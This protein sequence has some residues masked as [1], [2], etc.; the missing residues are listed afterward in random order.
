[1]RKRKQFGG[2]IIMPRKNLSL[3]NSRNAKRGLQK[4]CDFAKGILGSDITVVEVGAFSG[5]SGRIF[6]SNFAKV[7]S[8]DPWKSGYDSTGVDY[9]SDPAYYDMREV[10]ACFDRMTK[11]MGNVVKMKMSSKE[12]SQ[13]VNEPIR[14]VYIDA[15]HTYDGVTS[16]IGLWIDKI[17]RPGIICGHDYISKHHKGV[18]KAVD[19][20]FMNHPIDRMFP[21][22]S[23]L[24]ILN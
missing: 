21:D 15:W 1:M 9:A 13:K 10:E 12:A 23:W 2:G 3:R 6:A 24:K 14:L 5:D 22:S 7:I 4:L 11:E 19:E 18:R 8:V 16:D 20:Y 17:I